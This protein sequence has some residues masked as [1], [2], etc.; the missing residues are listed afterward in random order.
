MMPSDLATLPET[1]RNNLEFWRRLLEPL[2]SLDRGIT[3]ALE[4]LAK[5]H[6]LPYSTLRRKYDA[7]RKSGWMA[8]IDRRLCGPSAWITIDRSSISK[9]DIETLRTYCE[10]YQRSSAAGIREMRIDWLKGKIASSTPIDPATGY[11]VG[12]TERN[13][14]R[15]APTKY[16]L[17]AV[18][19]G[20]TAAASERSLVYTTRAGMAPGR[21][22][23]FDDMWHDHMTT[24]LD[25][26]K[27]G[28]PLEF[29]GL[30]L[31]SANKFAWG[32][33]VRT[34]G[35]S[36]KME[37]LKEA[38]MRFLLAAVL[39]LHGFNA[40][41]ATTLVVEHGTAAIPTWLEDL[42][43]D[44]TGGLIRVDRSGMEG[45]AAHAGQYP[46]RAKGNY[47]FKAALESLGNLIHNEMAA[48]P[49]QVG[50]D[51]NH[52]P[53][54][55]HGLVKYSDALLA[56]MS[57]LPRET[58]E[59]LIQPLLTIQ[60][61]RHVA[62]QIYTRINNRTDHDLE[63]WDMHYVADHTRPGMM[64]RKSPADIWQPARKRLT[65]LDPSVV[66]LMLYRDCAVERLT[67]SHMFQFQDGELTGDVL[68]FDASDL[69]DRE[70]YATVLN[71]FAPDQLYVFDAAGRFIQAA[72][73]ITS[74]PRADT[75][76]LHRACGEAASREAKLL[77]PLRI[78]HM[79]EAREKKRMH[80]HNANLIAGVTTPA[81]PASRLPSSADLTALT[82][83]YE[84]SE[85]TDDLAR[86]LA[87]LT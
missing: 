80:D 47:R 68:R 63:G 52:Y 20:R 17:K 32:M 49:G 37:G 79:A 77:Q 11:P 22:Y 62:D 36:G 6:G 65:R 23:L 18:R 35:E 40:E 83:S 29:H 84:A 82:D 31:A 58:A 59:L 64:R 39:S 54:S 57:Q 1:A 66:A 86:Q 87:D 8:V 85:D 9:A 5:Q 50:K 12:W 24:H 73:R 46:G 15:Y 72:P 69:A 41:T 70:K 2:L 53:E 56:A 33:R 42:L 45:A 28:R 81:V 61:F 14:S 74:V 3:S 25:Q 38:D 19:I 48:L 51:R 75:E 60:Q 34:E 30:D 55:T 76:A 10:R 21:Y 13:L 16:E 26:R 43:S 44:H 71:P 4:S 27:S 78:R 67:R 7:V